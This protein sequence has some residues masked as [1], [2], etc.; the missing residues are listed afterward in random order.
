MTLLPNTSAIIRMPV[1]P[2]SRALLI[3]LAACLVGAGGYALLRQTPPPQPSSPPPAVTVAAP[4]SRNVTEWDDYVGR[5]A[6]SRSVEVRPRVSGEILAIH[7]KDG[8]VVSEGQLLFSIDQR[9]FLAAQAEATANVASTQAA[10]ALAKA[11]LAR[12]G[13][14]KGENAVSAGDLDQLH[15]KEQEA[16]AAL[17]A[18]QARLHDRSLDIEFSE[19]RAPIAGLIS[20]RRV[21]IGN[22]V[23][24]SEG[25]NGT[26]LTTINALDPIYF[27]FDASE[28]LFLKTQ[29]SKAPDQHET[30]VEIRLLDDPDYRWKGALDFID[31]GLNP[32]SGTIRSRAT[33]AN[34]GMFLRPGLFGNM[35]LASQATANVVLVPDT[36]VQTDQ[37]RKIVLVVDRSKTVIAK[38]VVVGPLVQGLRIIRSGL[39]SDDQV[40]IDGMQGAIP[41][42]KVTPQPGQIAVAPNTEASPIEM[43][44]AAQ[45]TFN[46]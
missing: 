5:F 15:A 45:A 21:D 31:N 26:L 10:L 43:V 25:S 40:V 17:Q 7:F 30:P 33:I 13:R 6:P 9:R 2:R 32:R 19:V 12:V 24:G 18:A 3:L 28:A 27:E 41:G 38:P 37:A 16:E 4:L 34:P 36:A 46:R 8:D 20:S 29:R 23:A 1:R 35:R 14:L 11:D 42:N 22:L 44:P 39:S